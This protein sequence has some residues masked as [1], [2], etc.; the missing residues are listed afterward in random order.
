MKSFILLAVVLCLANAHNSSKEKGSKESTSAASTTTGA[1]SNCPT[2][3]PR[4]CP[5]VVC[6]ACDRNVIVIENRLRPIEVQIVEIIRETTIIETRIET[7]TVRMESTVDVVN[8]IVNRLNS[9][10][11]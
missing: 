1:P 11:S 6:E 9:M 5:D 8:Q 3:P 7:V 4:S 2:Q 10:T